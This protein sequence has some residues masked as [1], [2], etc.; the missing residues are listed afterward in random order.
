M[1]NSDG[2]VAWQGSWGQ[3]GQPHELLPC[4]CCTLER[5]YVGWGGL[6]GDCIAP[7]AGVNMGLWD[8]LLSRRG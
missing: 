7:N 2:T 3:A 5:V 1:R 4:L 6:G 8:R